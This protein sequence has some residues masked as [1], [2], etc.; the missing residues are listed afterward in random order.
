MD[1]SLAKKLEGGLCL[2]SNLSSYVPAPWTCAKRPGSSPRDPVR[3]E[4]MSCFWPCTAHGVRT[5]TKMECPAKVCQAAWVVSRVGYEGQI[6]LWK[7]WSQPQVHCM[8][9]V[10]TCCADSRETTAL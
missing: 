9:R 3:S 5:G 1:S 4:H 7:L 10:C 8:Y 6:G 2:L